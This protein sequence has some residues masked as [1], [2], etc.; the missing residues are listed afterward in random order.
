MS[1]TPDDDLSIDDLRTFVTAVEEGSLGSAARRLQQPKSTVSRRLHR[2]EEQL[3]TRLL[4]RTP[5]GLGQTDAGRVAFAPARAILEDL[6]SLRELARAGMA[7]PR[8]HL[9][10]SIPRDLAGLPCWMAFAQA[11]PQVVTELEFT[12]RYVD[13]V[14]EGFDLALRGGRGEDTTLIVRRVGT[15]RLRA[16]ASPAWLEEHGPIEDP[17]EVRTQECVLF[18]PFR[19]TGRRGRAHRRHL[20]ANDLS[21]VLDG[22]LRGLGIAFLPD[23]LCLEA[24][25]DQRLIAVH[26]DYDPLEIPLY[27]AYPDRRTM[28]AASSAFIDAVAEFFGAPDRP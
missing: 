7:E 9:K 18:A 28:P 24:L 2:L 8:G 23:H 19:Q 5:R 17:D 6:A 13:V 12:N 3:G 10:V 16:V 21:T 14:G 4:H 1:G 11:H 20:I 25:G 27:A 26:P 22:A 15:Y